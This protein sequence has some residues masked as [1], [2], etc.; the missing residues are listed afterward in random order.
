MKRI[1]YSRIALAALT[2]LLFLP[3]GISANEKK[4]DAKAP[5]GV[6]RYPLDRTY[7]LVGES[8]PI[9][10]TTGGEVTLR[11]EPQSATSKAI[12]IYQGPAQPIRLD[13]R[14][15]EPG[16]YKVV[17]NS[18]SESQ[19]M[20]LVS[21][22]REST[23][24]IINE[25][26]WPV[27]KEHFPRFRN[28]GVNAVFVMGNGASYS[29]RHLLTDDLLGVKTS[30]F[31]NPSTRPT[32]FEPPRVWD[33]EMNNY[34]MR[35]SLISQAHLRY[36][37]FGGICFE[38]DPSSVIRRPSIFFRYGSQTDEYHEY[39]R[40][41][42][43][44]VEEEFQE[45]TG[46]TPPTTKEFLQYVIAIGHPEYGPANDLPT[47]RWLEKIAKH[48]KP[49][50]KDELAR[51][52]KRVVAW[53]KHLMGVYGKGHKFF[54][55][56]LDK[57]DPSLAHT[58]SVNLDH[59][60]ITRGQYAPG[61]Y[62][63]LDFRHMSAWNDQIGIG[64]Y[65]FQWLLSAAL[66]NARNPDNQPI[67][68]AGATGVAHGMPG[69]CIRSAA[70]NLV[71]NGSGIGSAAEGGYSWLSNYEKS[72]IHRAK[73]GGTRE[74]LQRFSSLAT[75]AKGD[76]QVAI[77]YS[78]SDFAHRIAYEN[79]GSTAWQ[80]LVTLT[81]L[82]YTPKFITET[83][84]QKGK[85]QSYKVLTI[86]NQTFDLPKEVR[87]AIGRFT[88]N[89][90]RV[91]VDGSTTIELPGM[92]KMKQSI[93]EIE[94]RGV[95]GWSGPSQKMKP[96]GM[97]QI[98]EFLHRHLAPGVLKAIGNDVRSWYHQALGAESD[99]TLC[100][101]NAGPDARYVIAINDSWYANHWSHARWHQVKEKLLP[102]KKIPENAVL[103]DLNEE[104]LLGP[105]NKTFSCDLR[106]VTARVLAVVNRP[107]KT[108][109]L[110]ATQSLTT[111]SSIAIQACFLNDGKKQ[112][113]AVIP[114][115]LTIQR[116]DKSIAFAGFRCTNSEG[117]FAFTFP[118]GTNANIG[119]WRVKLRCQ[120][121]GKEASLPIRVKSGPQNF[122]AQPI[123][124]KV[125][126]RN[127]NAIRQLLETK[128]HL[129]APILPSKQPNRH[130]K[131]AEHAQTIV[132]KTG[133]NLRIW[134]NPEMSTYTLAYVPT[135]EQIKENLRIDK[136]Q[137]IGEI[138]RLTHRREDYYT[139]IGGYRCG[140]HLL[141][142]DL[143]NVEGDNPLAERL[144]QKGILWPQVTDS[145][146]GKGKAVIQLIHN[147]FD[148]HKSAII[149]QANDTE[150]LLE[151]AKALAHLPKDWIGTSVSQARL[152]LL[153]QWNIHRDSGDKENQLGKLT[154]QGLEVGDAPQPFRLDLS[155]IEIPAKSEEHEPPSQFKRTYLDLP[156]ATKD[157]A[158]KTVVQQRLR[159]SFTDVFAGHNKSGNP[160]LRFSDATMIPVHVDRA[161]DYKIL[162]QGIFRYSDRLPRSQ[163]SWE[164][165]LKLYEEVLP[166][167]RQPMVWQVQLNGKTVG[168]LKSCETANKEVPIETLPFYMKQ[169]PKSVS[170]KVVTKLCGIFS[171]PKGNHEIRL[172]YRNM[173]D[174]QLVRFSIQPTKN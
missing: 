166:R 1:N 60:P 58:A 110:R 146:P 156:I 139:D 100:Q 18:K 39:Q 63:N 11:L 101:I 103:Y 86:W 155:G 172:V 119:Q 105:A 173:V 33:L 102:S 137:A 118:V 93:Y 13:T 40:R 125:V 91:I 21:P 37:A 151:G 51:L 74:F 168:K 144:N 171:L 152:A 89:G 116:P 88:K 109:D 99:V 157:I 147:A 87:E 68:I 4:S 45:I 78:K 73:I 20:T 140:A 165:I 57:I 150:G 24:A 6:V 84:I 70:H 131:A 90:G 167:K 95:Y 98:S 104:K 55:K 12:Q 59:G 81:R 22:F 112:L 9:G 52:Q 83:E 94:A 42:N 160:D 5:P 26:V 49:L 36:P 115:H 38:W 64:D 61:G 141:L 121:T 113:R 35:L 15:L 76:H 47:T 43:K 25:Q 163:G 62:Q 30:L 8:I 128:A 142:F 44:A 134:R 136:G 169:K 162:F 161:G 7:Y 133:A 56:H 65:D 145:F 129:V 92:E 71:Q 46:L 32:S 82:G 143:A 97:A 108:M 164:D 154:S 29:K 130:L 28:S 123:Q 117:N 106:K 132:K 3:H 127:S 149:V 17:V 80:A 107:I 50:P 158:K 48:M 170:E 53:H 148:P 159:G 10:F 114:L 75:Q 2:T 66:M 27:R 14:L 34:L 135:K 96:L 85:L 67:W 153:R 54:Q 31:L 72:E 122:Q 79:L 126:V 174:G 77:L 111:G 41:S 138:A 120:L 19:T 23:A 124:A 16:T 69:K